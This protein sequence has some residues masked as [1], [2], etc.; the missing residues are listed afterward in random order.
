M[1]APLQPPMLHYVIYSGFGCDRLD[2]VVE[3]RRI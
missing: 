2:V 1:T 3:E